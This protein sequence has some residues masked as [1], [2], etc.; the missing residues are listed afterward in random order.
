MPPSRHADFNWAFFGAALD[1]GNLGVSALALSTLHELYRRHPESTPLLFDNGRGHRTEAISIADRSITVERRGGWHSRRYYRPE[2][3]TSMHVAA[4]FAPSLNPNTRALRDATAVLDVSGG[5]SFAQTYGRHRFE[6]VAFPKRIALA[7]DRPLVLLPQTYGPF[8]DADIR[9]EAA[10]IT[11]RATQVWARDENSY[12]RLQELLGPRFDAARH[13]H[14]A[15]VAFALPA[16]LPDPERMSETLASWFDDARPSI[17]VNVSGLLALEP[18]AR[19]RYGLGGDYLAA[20][21]TFVRTVLDTTDLRVLLVPHVYGANESDLEASQTVVR[22]IGPQER[23][24]VLDARLGADEVKY[25]IGKMDF[26]IGARM[27]STIAALSSG[28]PAAAVA[29]S[30]KFAGVFAACGLGQRVLDARRL[31]AD[32]LSQAALDALGHRSSDK[33]VLAGQLPSVR[34]RVQEQFDEIARIAF[35]SA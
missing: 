1:S 2:S 7:L 8:Q 16:K 27:H 35:D 10:E 28:V 12:A 30:D 17:G 22:S 29:Y 18:G 32:D 26:F 5:D 15:D 9:Q 23:L 24:A 14:G 13:R 11:S 21:T 19:A 3:L 4:R 34:Q 33:R 25:A 6:T 31:S 20:M